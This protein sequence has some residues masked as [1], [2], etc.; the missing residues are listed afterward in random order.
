[1]I[2]YSP[3][4]TASIK[5]PTRITPINKY[6]FLEAE[7]GYC[8]YDADDEEKQ[9]MN[10]ISTPIMDETELARKYVVVQGDAEKLNE[11]LQKAV[12]DDQ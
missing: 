10:S 11:E 7:Y 12:Q 4:K 6:C 1:M 5:I 8:F 3:S 9:Y 2:Y